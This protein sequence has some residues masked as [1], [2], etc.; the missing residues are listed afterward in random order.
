MKVECSPPPL[1]RAISQVAVLNI[2]NESVIIYMQLTYI[3]K[4]IIIINNNQI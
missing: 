2:T 4:F 1:L 3:L